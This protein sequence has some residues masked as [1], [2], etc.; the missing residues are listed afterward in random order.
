M[1]K[2]IKFRRTFV[3][4]ATITAPSQVIGEGGN[5]TLLPISEGVDNYNREG[6][7]I[8]ITEIWVKGVID[9]RPLH[10]PT[11]LNS[12]PNYA[13]VFDV[14]IMLD[15]RPN[16]ATPAIS[17]MYTNTVLPWAFLN[18]ETPTDR[19][20]ELARETI[21][22]NV[23]PINAR[24][25]AWLTNLFPTS[26]VSTITDE[27][28][29]AQTAYRTYE[30]K[31]E[32]LRIPVSYINADGLVSSIATNNIFVVIGQLSAMTNGA[33]YIQMSSRVKFVE[34]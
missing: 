28:M 3:S 30:F 22:I 29:I 11:D 8:I 25:Y 26:E 27:V 23:P 21:E 4:P 6:S 2:E 12:L 33:A 17:D 1:D 32:D 13:N 20:V 16:G 5:F 34:D 9:F 18:E 10:I 24:A 7:K 31:L 15:K 19:F 14:V